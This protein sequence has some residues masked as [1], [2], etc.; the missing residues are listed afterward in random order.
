MSK[1]KFNRVMGYLD[2]IEAEMDKIA[3]ATGH[4]TF[5]EWKLGDLQGSK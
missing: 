4:P 1:E 5:K 2:I 3:V